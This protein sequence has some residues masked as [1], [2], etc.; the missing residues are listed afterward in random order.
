MGIKNITDQE[1]WDPFYLLL[2]KVLNN[3]NDTS[4]INGARVQINNAPTCGP[5][6]YEK[7]IDYAPNGWASTAKFWH[8]S[9]DQNNGDES[10]LGNYDGTDY[11]LLYNLY[12][13]SVEPVG[14]VNLIDR[15][16]DGCYYPFY[17]ELG[18]GSGF[19]VGNNQHPDTIQAFE[20][21]EVS[22]M[23]VDN[24]LHP[25]FGNP[26]G[27][28]P[29]NANVAMRAGKKIILKPGFKVEKGAYFH[30]YIEP[31]ECSN[32]DDDTPSVKSTDQ[33]LYSY[34]PMFTLTDSLYCARNYMP[35]ENNSFETTEILISEENT[36][37]AEDSNIHKEL[38]LSIY[39]NPCDGI[40]YI[41]SVNYSNQE[42]Q[43]I[44]FNMLGNTV[45]SATNYSGEFTIDMSQQPAGIYYVNINADNKIF[46]KKVV[47]N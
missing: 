31:F 19:I 36:E 26:N 41:S 39:P 38:S 27:T 47:V 2:C 23:I 17:I 44:V 1:N 21:I 33:G 29:E 9:D 43:V 28:T 14:Y 16:L 40:F 20:T 45:Y 18:F 30:A 7:N 22:N 10:N 3:K 35:M 37:T 34:F 12:R 4:F 46:R 8:S 5:Y 24:K 15:K 11:M 13:L 25:D 6:C 32:N 42:M